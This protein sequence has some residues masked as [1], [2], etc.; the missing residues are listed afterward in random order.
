VVKATGGPGLASWD[1]ALA[2]VWLSRGG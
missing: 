2:G 1:R